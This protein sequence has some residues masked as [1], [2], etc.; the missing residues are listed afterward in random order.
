MLILAAA[1]IGLMSAWAFFQNGGLPS[2]TDAELHV[3]RTAEL[4][5]S[6]AAGNPY[7]R[8]APDFY[9]GLGYPIFN[10]YAPLTYFLGHLLTLGRPEYAAI[11]AKACFVLAHVIGAVGA[12]M[13][14]RLFGGEGGGLLG[15]LAYA[16][17]PYIQLIDPYV[18]GDL[19]ETFALACL[20]WALWSWEQVWRRG[21]A[22]SG[23]A[24]VMSTSV[25]FL[26]HNLTGLSCLA[27]VAGLSLWHWRFRRH[28]HL[29]LAFAAGTAFVLITAFFWLPFLLERSAVQLNVAGDGHYDFRNHFVTLRDLLAW[30]TPIDRRATAA[31]VP[32]T[33]GPQILALAVVGLILTALTKWQKGLGFYAVAGGIMLWLTTRSSQVAWEHLPGLAYFQFPW[34]FLG[35]AA[36]LLVP[37]V[38]ALGERRRPLRSPVKRGAL[39]DRELLKSRSGGVAV[40]SIAALALLV[41]GLVGLY[42]LPWSSGF[43]RITPETLIDA[44]L[45]GRWRGTTSTN[46]FVPTT[47]TMIPGPQPTL[48]ASYENPPVD[49]VN[50]A[51]LPSSANVTVVPDRPW[52]NRFAVSSATE[53]TLR[54][55][56]FQFPGWR[57][58]VDG[59][60]V[61]ITVAQPEGFI[62]VPVPSGDHEVVVRFGTTPARTIGWIVSGLGCMALTVLGVTW[63]RPA[64]AFEVVSSSTRVLEKET[65]KPSHQQ[66]LAR[67]AALGVMAICVATFVVKGVWLDRLAWLHPMSP[68]G[69]VRGAEYQQAADLGGQVAL[70]GFDLSSTSVRPAAPLD[71]TLYWQARQPVTATYQ[72]FVHLVNPE[73]D[74]WSQSDHLNPGGFPTDL[75]PT[76]RYVTDEHR[77]QLPPDLPEGT[78]L[79]S[80]GLYTLSEGNARLPVVSAECG[81]RADAVVLCKPIVVRR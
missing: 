62:T 43:G 34:R 78:Y 21:T 33:V 20:P 44:E 79:L 37:P 73:G 10:Y 32:M 36:A 31:N 50:R 54:L 1:G 56:L 75:W 25:V 80:I 67:G 35:P 18:R 42:P 17:A 11:G 30:V 49:R 27:L 2:G 47:V 23:V 59:Q 58:Y 38:A 9:Y 57:A 66:P 46:D 68:M 60:Q 69:E 76:D 64:K 5:F 4:G 26:S 61:D 19:A 65:P 45:E 71:V 7:P 74:I 24:A 52:V 72:S 29:L 16:F 40:A 12:Y 48:L 15:A 77:L 81:R 41:G 70:L 3:Y 6:L 13:L 39:P 22:G 14:G 55:F 8:W 28:P 53:F 63:R 51:T